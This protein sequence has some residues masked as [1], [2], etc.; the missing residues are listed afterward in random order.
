MGNQLSSLKQNGVVK[1][2]EQP[3]QTPHLFMLSNVMDGEMF[4]LIASSKTAKEVKDTLY[5]IFE[6]SRCRN[7][8]KEYNNKTLKR[9]RF[10]I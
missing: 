7:L 9:D 4:E 2:R 6:R 3:H 10:E 5:K 8:K 1:K